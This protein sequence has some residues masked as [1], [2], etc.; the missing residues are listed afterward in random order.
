MQ[1]VSK[2]EHP[3]RL[4]FDSFIDRL[5]QQTQPITQSSSQYKIVLQTRHYSD[6][7]ETAYKYLSKLVEKK[8]ITSSGMEWFLDNYYILQKAIDLIQEDLPEEYFRKLPSPV[9]SEGIPR[10]YQIAKQM[11]AH[12]EVDVVL[13]S[14][15][16]TLSEYQEKVDL[17]MSE[18]WALPLMLRLVMIEITTAFIFDLD[19][20]LEP[21]HTIE[22]VDFPDLNADEV[23]ARAIRSLIHFDQVDWKNLFESQS[24]VEEVLR[25]DPAKI[26]ARMDFETRDQYRK[27]IETLAGGS[28][29]SEIDIAK[30]AIKMA[31]ETSKIGEKANHVGYYLIAEGKDNLKKEIGFKPD[32]RERFQ[33]VLLQT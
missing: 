17:Q 6:D 13:T 23:V 12:Y 7:L 24:K 16:R 19:D 15:D 3:S 22:R 31:R 26:Y 32:F 21:D 18:L 28:D 11:V 9:Q 29:L 10:I 2:P 25:T 33:R 1:D 5:I 30:T 4:S 14:I 8:K 27:T 20:E